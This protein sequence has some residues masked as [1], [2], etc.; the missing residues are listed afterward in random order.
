[1]GSVCC[2]LVAS[3]RFAG[4]EA[5]TGLCLATAGSKGLHLLQALVLVATVIFK[6]PLQSFHIAGCDCGLQHINTFAKLCDFL[7]RA[8]REVSPEEKA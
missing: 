2:C 1:M 7:A 5:A 4:V 6:A 8:I 3:L